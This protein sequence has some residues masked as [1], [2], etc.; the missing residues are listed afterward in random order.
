VLYGSVI[1][2]ILLTIIILAAT[3]TN[4]NESEFNTSDDS[5]IQEVVDAEIIS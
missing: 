1:A 2:A 4:R 3:L 5:D